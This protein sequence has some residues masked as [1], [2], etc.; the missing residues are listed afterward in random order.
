[1]KRCGW[2]EFG[3]THERFPIRVDIHSGEFEIAL[4]DNYD[5]EKFKG[6]EL[7]KLRSDAWTY[8]Q[9][10][11]SGKWE[12]F[13]IVEHNNQ[14]I[15]HDH[16]I[17]FEY[18][19]VFRL[20]KPDGTLLWKTWHGPDATHEGTPGASCYGPSVEDEDTH[21]KCLRY[22][23]Q[24][25]E[26]LLAITWAIEEVDKKIRAMVAGADLEAKL[27]CIAAG[28]AHALPYDGEGKRQI[29]RKAKA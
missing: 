1:M 26:G 12:P 21:V 7:D 6:K 5:N 13:V 29:A 18:K 16:Q 23:R 2:F 24:V 4:G 25:W 10:V 11:T 3:P 9:D 22:S 20:K 14:G 28:T 15:Q 27:K 8:L 19:R 17:Y